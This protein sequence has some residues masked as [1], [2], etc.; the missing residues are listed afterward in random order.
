MLTPQ[1]EKLFR[2]I[3]RIG[4][5]YGLDVIE[6]EFEFENY[7]PD[8]TFT[9][10]DFTTVGTWYNSHELPEKVA[11]EIASFINENVFVKLEKILEGLHDKNDIDEWST[12]TLDIIFDLNKK[13]FS[14]KLQANW[15]GT[16]DSSEEFDMPENMYD[17]NVSSAQIEYNGGGDSGYWD[18]SMK[19]YT[20]D[21]NTEM[22]PLPGQINDWISYNLPGGWEINEGSSGTVDF[23]FNK[24]TITI[25]HSMNTFEGDSKMVLEFEF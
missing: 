25:F 2:L 6:Y 14:A 21:G 9:L 23:D 16:E 19:V 11:Q 5:S 4:K 20:S 10:N 12:I 7:I 1:Q 13:R 24:K 22:V 8:T 17:E 18:D 3:Y 15:Y